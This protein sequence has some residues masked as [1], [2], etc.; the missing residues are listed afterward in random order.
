VLVKELGGRQI[1]VDEDGFI[2]DPDQ[3]NQDVAASLAETEGVTAMTDEHWKVVN[4]LREYYLEFNMAPMIRKLCK[5]TGFK[6]KEIYD[7]FPSGPAKGACKV[8]GLPKPTG[9]V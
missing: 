1:E 5:A 3:W 4:Y 8:A 2:Q 7:L 9:C 6:L